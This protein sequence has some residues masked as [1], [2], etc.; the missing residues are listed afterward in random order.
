MVV[1]GEVVSFARVVESELFEKQHPHNLLCSN[2]FDIIRI[3]FLRKL[4]CHQQY[5]IGFIILFENPKSAR[6]PATAY[7]MFLQK[8]SLLS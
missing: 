6:G 5:I 8:S 3:A 7:F 4:A 1:R 2:R